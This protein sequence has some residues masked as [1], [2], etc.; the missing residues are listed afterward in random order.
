MMRCGRYKA[1]E[2][3][4]ESAISHIRLSI[5]P[6]E[7]LDGC[8]T[9][10]SS[11]YSFLSNNLSYANFDLGSVINHKVHHLMDGF[12]FIWYLSIGCQLPV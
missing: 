5:I 2:N 1:W 6:C 4:F 11:L 3:D 9:G 12:I 10:N 8:A 7:F